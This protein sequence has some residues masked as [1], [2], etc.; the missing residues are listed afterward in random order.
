M[1]AILPSLTLRSGYNIHYTAAAAA[2]VDQTTE[3][4]SIEFILVFVI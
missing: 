3:G 2:A 1:M 4:K